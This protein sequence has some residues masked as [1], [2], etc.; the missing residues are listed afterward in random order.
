MRFW[1]ENTMQK[2]KKNGKMQKMQKC[3]RIFFP[4]LSH[5]SPGSGSISQALSLEV[6]WWHCASA[7][8][9]TE[10]S[11]RPSHSEAPTHPP[12]AP[13]D[14]CLAISSNKWPQPPHCAILLRKRPELESLRI[15]HERKLSFIPSGWMKAGLIFPPPLLEGKGEVRRATL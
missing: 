12:P 14:P 5:G 15:S 11:V 10:W 6:A 3:V 8:S 4:A 2:I 9:G 1:E 7:I 13:P